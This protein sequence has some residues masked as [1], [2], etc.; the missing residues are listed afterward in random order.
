MDNYLQKYLTS[1]STQSDF[2]PSKKKKRVQSKVVIHDADD[3][4]IVSTKTRKAKEYSDEYKPVVVNS[5]SWQQEEVERS[6]RQEEIR[7]GWKVVNE[8]IPQQEVPV[9]FSILQPENHAK[10]NEEEDLSPPRRQDLSPPRQQQPSIDNDNDH[11]PRKRV[12]H[13]SD[14]EE[15]V[16]LTG[17]MLRTSGIQLL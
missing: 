5:N 12:R 1:N 11:A 15:E 17:S 8:G 2:K 9:S 3:E 14:D 13:D 7:K 16:D 10:K 6:K 4:I